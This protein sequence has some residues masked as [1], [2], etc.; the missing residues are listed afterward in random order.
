MTKR[1][2][3]AAIKSSALPVIFCAIDTPEL[4]IALRLSKSLARA[5]GSVKLGLDSF[6]VI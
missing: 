4:Q 5:T 6:I 2:T 1:E 3:K